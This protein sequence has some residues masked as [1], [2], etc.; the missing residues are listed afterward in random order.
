MAESQLVVVAMIIDK[1]VVAWCHRADVVV[2]GEGDGVGGGVVVGDGGPVHEDETMTM[3]KNLHM[4]FTSANL[5]S[6]FLRVKANT[7][8]RVIQMIGMIMVLN[9]TH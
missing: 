7:K 1:R 3:I 6:L 5:V 8:M 9:G 4:W 2:V